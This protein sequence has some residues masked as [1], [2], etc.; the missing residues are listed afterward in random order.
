MNRMNWKIISLE[1]KEARE[2]LEEIEK[3]IQS[4][5]YPDE[6]GELK[7]ML[8]HAYHHLNAAWNI[9]RIETKDY[10]NLTD[11]QFNKWSRY[12]KDIDVFELKTKRIK[13]KKS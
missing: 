3:R 13:K 1:L 2:R 11:A 4:K 10:A 7:P 5:Q 6:V 9:R 12:P 8:E